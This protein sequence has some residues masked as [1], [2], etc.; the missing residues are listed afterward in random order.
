MPGRPRLLDLFCGAGGAGMGYHRAGF[1][2]VG[3]DVVRQPRYPFEFHLANALTFPLA[4]FDAVHA[5]PPCKVRTGARRV[6]LARFPVLFDP[7]PDLLGPTL[8]R[9]AAEAPGPW[10][11]ENVPGPRGGRGARRSPLPTRPI[12]GPGPEL[13]EVGAPVLLCG[14]TF[15]LGVRRHRLFW[16]SLELPP[17]PACQHAGQGQILGVYGHT[18]GTSRRDGASSFGDLAAW[19]VAMGIDWMQSVELAQAIPPAYTEWLG[20]HLLAAV[21]G[22]EAPDRARRS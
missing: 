13:Q 10:I 19:R 4:G 14:S 17:P 20:R 18:G 7:H 8:A 21:V 15:G 11:V 5:S 22:E 9:L 12:R 16:S 2:V 1:D 3:V 6:S